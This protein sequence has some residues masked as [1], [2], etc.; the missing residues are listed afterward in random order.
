MYSFEL[1][2][3]MYSMETAP[4]ELVQLHEPIT[5]LRLDQSKTSCIVCANNRNIHLLS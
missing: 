4:N 5:S 1:A 2:Q 3:L